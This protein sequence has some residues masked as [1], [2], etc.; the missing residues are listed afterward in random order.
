MVN[1]RI[2]DLE[3]IMDVNKALFSTLDT[4]EILF[5]IVKKISEIIQV[6]RCSII[7]IDKD[8]S[9][10]QI[11]ATYED[12]AL[13]TLTIDLN[14][15]PEI[16]KAV[17]DDKMVLILDA[18]VDPIMK[19]VRDKILSL[20]IK[21]IMVIPIQ[22]SKGRIGALYLRTSRKAKKFDEKEI[23]VCHIISSI[24]A[25]A[26][27]NAHLFNI[28]REEKLLLEK[29]AVTDDLTRLYNHR[30]FV[31][32]LNEEFKR[33]KRYKSQISCAM[34]D[35]D[36]FKR[37]NDTNGH[38]KGD[39]ILADVARIIK[40]SVRETD[41]VARYGGEEFSVILPH[42]NKEDASNLANRIKD[43]VRNFKFDLL[44]EGRIITV[45][46][47]IST[48]PDPRIEDTDDLVRI[49]DDGLYQAKHCGKDL[50]I[51]I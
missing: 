30:Y 24:A 17:E 22:Y 29:M 40:N 18:T 44:G 39:V 34:I 26:L 38:Q 31:K 12:P 23:K 6:A 47:G 8:M 50:V 28:I 16:V 45:S 37:V 13:N 4:K 2:D 51:S 43:A 25:I 7:L 46:I 27:K 9:I 36:N 32:R 11:I 5:L 42:T 3:N 49:A 41:V 19:E 10:G 48:Y 1:K 33:A 35:V 21:S 20:D 14:K 15:Y